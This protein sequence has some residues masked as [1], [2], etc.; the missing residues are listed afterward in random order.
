MVDSPELAAD[1]LAA[2]ID[3][4]VV[5]ELIDGPQPALLWDTVRGGARLRFPAGQP[6]DLTV[7]R[8]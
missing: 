7:P 5:H 6:K 4:V 3:Y 1:S 2:V 8:W